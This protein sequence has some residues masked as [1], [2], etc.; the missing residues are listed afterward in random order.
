[1]NETID[2]SERHCGVE[3]DLS[4]F[5]DRLVCSDETS[6]DLRSIH[7]LASYFNSIELALL[8]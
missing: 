5:A 2:R 6:I 4:P 1:M 3:K 8:F 7:K